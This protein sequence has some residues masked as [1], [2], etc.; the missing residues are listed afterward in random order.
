MRAWRV[1]VCAH[2]VLADTRLCG[3]V[4]IRLCGVVCIGLCGVLWIGVCVRCLR[5]QVSVCEV[6]ADTR[7]CALADLSLSPRT[8]THSYIAH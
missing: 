6:L 4:C 1:A 3:V 7:L 5:T 2:G 8:L